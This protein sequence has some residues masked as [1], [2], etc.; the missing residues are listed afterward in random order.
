MTAPAPNA[1]EPARRWRWPRRM[2][3]AAIILVFAWLALEYLS[4]WGA[5]RQLARVMAELDARDPKWRWKDLQAA[6]PAIP[7][8]DNG[9][10]R[11]LAA[12]KL[13]G[14]KKQPISEPHRR[15]YLRMTPNELLDS[16]L[17]KALHAGRDSAAAA[18]AEARRLADLPRG[19]FALDFSN[20]ATRGQWNNECWFITVLLDLDAALLAED[21]DLDGALRSCRGI[22]HESHYL[23]A[24]RGLADAGRAVQCRDIAV[25]TIERVLG[26]GEVSQ[27]DLNQLQTLCLEADRYSDMADGLAAERAYNEYLYQQIV[28]AKMSKSDL[29]RMQGGLRGPSPYR[30]GWWKLDDVLGAWHH[31]LQVGSPIKNLAAHLEFDT[32]MIA[33]ARMRS[34][35]QSEAIRQKEPAWQTLPPVVSEWAKTVISH[36]STHLYSKAHLRC[37]LAAFAIERFRLANGRWPNDTGELVPQFLSQVPNDPCAVGTVGYR[38]TDFGVETYSA[39]TPYVP[40]GA[41]FRLWDPKKRRQPP[42][43]PKMNSADS[44]RNESK[45]P[46]KK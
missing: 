14:E 26:H 32:Q 5:N 12:F 37:G 4:D 28:Q 42:S 36:N 19:Q 25:S 24:G 38:K 46:D 6:R 16:E 17:S 40:A 44:A 27:A 33:I 22:W 11:L 15:A 29:Q 43:V 1:A 2:S 8:D 45:P 39:G 18:L 35:Q 3:F 23:R 21:G 31:R 7:A 41:R 20:L 9:A 10:L 13:L 30:T 34:E